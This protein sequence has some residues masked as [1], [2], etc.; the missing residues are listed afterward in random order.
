MRRPTGQPVGVLNPE[1]VAEKERALLVVVAERPGLRMCE[2]AALV[3]EPAAATATRLNRLGDRGLIERVGRR[4]FIAGTAPDDANVP[5]LSEFEI[6]ERARP[7]FDPSRWMQNIN[8]FVRQATSD[9]QC[10]RYG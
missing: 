9:F 10:A 4:W 3:T 5:E 7:P 6:A 8:R 1:L 2:I